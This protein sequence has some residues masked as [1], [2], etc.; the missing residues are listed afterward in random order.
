MGVLYFVENKGA[1][2]KQRER[3]LDQ[4]QDRQASSIQLSSMQC[5]QSL[6]SAHIS[7]HFK[8]ALKTVGFFCVRLLMTLSAIFF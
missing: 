1:G 4:Y 2:E 7:I 5:S 3:L 8:Y 6:I